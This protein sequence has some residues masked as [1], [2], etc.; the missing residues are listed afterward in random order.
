MPATQST[1]RRASLFAAR[2]LDAAMGRYVTSSSSMMTR[3]SFVSMKKLW[4]NGHGPFRMMALSA[5]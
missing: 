5:L 2:L 1:T 4:A 3:C